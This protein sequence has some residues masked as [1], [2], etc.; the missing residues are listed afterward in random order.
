MNNKFKCTDSNIMENEFLGDNLLVYIE[1]EFVKSFD[2]E[3][4]LDDFVSLRPRRMQFYAL[5]ILYL[6][7]PL[8]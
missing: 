3:L 7:L 5:Y 8:Y 4:I 2:S 6:P 1:N